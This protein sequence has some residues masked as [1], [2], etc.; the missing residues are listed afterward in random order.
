MEGALL[1]TRKEVR[2]FS[3]YHLSLTSQILLIKPALQTSQQFPNNAFFYW[4]LLTLQ[5]RIL[6]YKQRSAYLTW[7]PH[8]KP[9]NIMQSFNQMRALKL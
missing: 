2:P 4:K 8:A 6:V 9:I 1:V 5:L 3:L 7:A